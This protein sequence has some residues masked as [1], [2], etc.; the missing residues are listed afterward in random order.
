MKSLQMMIKQT[1]MIK[2]SMVK[3]AAI[4]YLKEQRFYKLR[5]KMTAQ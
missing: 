1:L 5:V 4:I 2:K 3:V